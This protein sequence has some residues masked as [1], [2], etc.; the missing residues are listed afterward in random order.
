VAQ[1][2]EPEVGIPWPW[3]FQPDSAGLLQQFREALPV[4]I[5]AVQEK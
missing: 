4:R 5:I 2:F 1:K 3:R